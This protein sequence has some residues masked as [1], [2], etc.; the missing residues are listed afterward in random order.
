M[1]IRSFFLQHSAEY[2]LWLRTMVV[3]HGVVG[4]GDEMVGDF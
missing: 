4:A 2:F 1:A 3:K